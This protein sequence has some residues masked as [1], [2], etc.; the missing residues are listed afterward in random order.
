MTVNP[1]F[2]RSPSRPVPD[3]QSYLQQKVSVS[4]TTASTPIAVATSH[5]YQIQVIVFG[6][7]Y[8]DYVA[9]TAEWRLDVEACQTLGGTYKVVGSTRLASSASGLNPAVLISP[10]NVQAIVPGAN[11]FRVNA[12]KVGTP[13]PLSYGAYLSPVEDS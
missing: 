8:T 2:S 12:V 7:A 6:D 3:A 13:G 5:M 11:F 1:F 9:G 4:A 10:E